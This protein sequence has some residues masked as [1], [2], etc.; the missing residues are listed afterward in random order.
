MSFEEIRNTKGFVFKKIVDKK[1]KSAALKYLISKLN[2]KGKEKK[3]SEH[4]ECQGYLLPNNILT[5]HE[6][7]K[8]DGVGPIDNRPSTE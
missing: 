6:Q 2:S 7:R 5:V 1:V 4:L 8:L 3:F